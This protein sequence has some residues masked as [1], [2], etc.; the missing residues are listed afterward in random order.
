MSCFP[1]VVDGEV[2]G[3][4]SVEVPT[5]LNHISEELKETAFELVTSLQQMSMAIDQI[6]NTV[7]K[8]AESGQTITI[9]SQGVHEK[10]LKT[11]EVVHY[12]DSIAKNTKLLGL[13]FNLLRNQRNIYK[14]WRR[15]CKVVSTV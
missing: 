5:E 7:Q 10:S 15:N 14:V 1:L 11:D 6:S 12:I 8:L 4:M 2:I 13:R 9:D 3:G